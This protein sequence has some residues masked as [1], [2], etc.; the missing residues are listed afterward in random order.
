MAEALSKLKIDYSEVRKDVVAAGLDRVLAQY[1]NS[2]LFKKLL[3]V[4]LKQ[5][6]QLYDAIIDLQEYRT[7]YSATG[8]TLDG[9][10]R[11]VGSN[12][13]NFNY[14]DTY[15]FAPDKAGVGCDN[16]YAW[17]KNAPQAGISMQNDDLYRNSIWRKAISNFVK[18]GSVPEIQ[19]VVSAYMDEP[20]G[21]ETT[22]PFTGTLVVSADIGLTNLEI[23]TYTQNT[24]Q[25][26][27]QFRIPY[28]TT[29]DFEGVVFYVP[30]NAFAPDREGVGADNGR[31]AVR[32]RV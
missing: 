6:Q 2:Y 3:S 21:F 20:V 10:G 14:S 18:F 12:R 13:Q 24:E 7:I 1:K 25:V 15:Y 16:G 19:D 22:N 30:Q 29:T 11:I 28:P 5:C 31:A 23:L 9:L 26:E 4:W 8:D 17:C 32:G 27:H